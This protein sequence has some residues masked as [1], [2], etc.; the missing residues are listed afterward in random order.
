MQNPS[1]RFRPPTEEEKQKEEQQ[2]AS[3]LVEPPTGEAETE[4]D[5]DDLSNVCQL[6]RLN[7]ILVDPDDGVLKHLCRQIKEYIEF[8]M[9]SKHYEALGL[10]EVYRAYVDRLSQTLAGED[11]I[12]VAVEDITLR[13]GRVLLILMFLLGT[14]EVETRQRLHAKDRQYIQQDFNRDV[15]QW[16]I[17]RDTKGEKYDG[18]A[19]QEH[20][21]DHHTLTFVLYQMSHYR[22]YYQFPK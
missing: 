14:P 6:R 8:R 13:A 10:G 3:Q 22:L 16:L 18:V 2:A 20:L 12:D 4:E 21:L 7:P 15:G 19:R 9:K 1:L 5:Y 11:E 17:G